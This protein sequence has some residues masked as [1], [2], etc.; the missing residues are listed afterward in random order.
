MALCGGT[1]GSIRAYLELTKPKITW[2]ILMS[3]AVG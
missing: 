1:A 3:T 2:L